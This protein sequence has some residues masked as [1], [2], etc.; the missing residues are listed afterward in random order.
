MARGSAVIEGDPRPVSVD[1]GWFA[2]WWQAMAARPRRTLCWLLVVATLLRA[3]FW[4]TPFE[5]DEG[6]FLMVAR[7]WHGPGVGLYTDQWVDRPPLL[8]IVF[9]LGVW[10]GG[11]R[12]VVRLI[13]LLCGLVT[14]VAAYAAGRIINGSTG[15]VV[16]AWVATFASSSFAFHGFA[17]TGEA[18]AGAFV[19][20]SCA[21]LLQATYG[22]GTAARRG[23]LAVA[24]GALAML[25][26]LS[27]QNFLDAAVFAFALLVVRAHRTWRLM[28]AYAVGVALPLLA[29]LGWALSSDGPGLNRLYVALF[30]FRQRSLTVI[31]DASLGAPLERLRW[32]LVLFVVSGLALLAW[33]TVSGAIRTDGRRS[34]RVALVVMLVYVGFSIAAGASWWTHYLLQLAAVL[35]MGTALATGLTRPAWRRFGPATYV[36]VAAVY[37]SVHGVVAMAQGDIPA[38]QDQKVADFLQEASEPGDSVVLAYG[39]PSVIEESGLSTPYR[40]AWSLPVRTRDPELTL[41][42]ATLDGPDAPTW[43]VE[44]GDFDWWDLDNSAFARVRAEHYGKV[45]E[46]CGHAV[47]LHLD[48]ERSLPDLPDSC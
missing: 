12:V 18:I 32:L 47:Y 19:M 46:V 44:V 28:V 13:A 29:T 30:R 33:Q 1:D 45:A 14:I 5:S 15:A 41:L 37:A 22:D 43:L 8:L 25:A 16:A 3:L 11:E 7:Q 34:L 10:L 4:W 42:V 9:K 2:R 23:S 39:S 17:L 48:A 35:A 36:A 20:A 38:Q 24:A 27:K 26:F 6:G 40:Y 31:E 21:L